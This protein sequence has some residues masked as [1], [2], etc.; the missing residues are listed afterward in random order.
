M[1]LQW[2]TTTAP[3]GTVVGYPEIKPG[4]WYCIGIALPETVNAEDIRISFLTWT[5]DGMAC[6]PRAGSVYMDGIA[7]FSTPVPLKEIAARIGYSDC[8]QFSR[9]YKNALVSSKASDCQKTPREV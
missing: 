9:I 1:K 6:A 5:M 2:D 7:D 8:F 3:D 4:A